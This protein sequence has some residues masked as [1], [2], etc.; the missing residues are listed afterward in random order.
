MTRTIV[1]RTIDAPLD[2]VFAAVADIEQLP[3]VIPNV[4]KI[5]ILSRTDAVVGTCFRETRLMNG[6]QALT[7]LEVAEYVPNVRIRM[8]ADSHGTVWDS[9]FKVRDEGGHTELSL[10]MDADAHKLLPSLLSPLAKGLIKKGLDQ[11]M[12]AVKEYCE[13]RTSPPGN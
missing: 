6:K 3:E 13:R 2:V 1:K 5:E 10:T 4:V 12:D 9:V 11:H 7:E 8:V